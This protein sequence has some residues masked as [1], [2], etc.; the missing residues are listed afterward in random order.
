M[1]R[2]LETS[3]GQFHFI[4]D[5]AAARYAILSHTWG[6]PREGG[7]QSYADIREIQA[8]VAQE[9]QE[10]SSA[11]ASEA[12][13]EHSAAGPSILSHP[14]LSK[15][16]KEFCRVAREAGYHIV[17]IDSCCIDKSSSAE[18]SEAINSMFEWYS[19]ADVCCVYL[20]D[21]PEGDDLAEKRG[22]FRYSR[23]HR[24]G[25]TLQELIA[26]K[27]MVFFSRSWGFL[28]TKAGLAS[29]LEKI[30]GVDAAVL[31]GMTPLHSISVARRMSWASGRMTTLVE[32]EAY[33]LMGIFGV[34]LSPI[35]GERS[36][37]FVRLQEE[38]IRTI[39]DQSIFAWGPTC[40]LP[41]LQTVDNPFGDLERRRAGEFRPHEA[42][43]LAKSPGDFR[44]CRDVVSVSRKALSTLLGREDDSPH[45][46]PPL[47]C[48]FTPEGVRI[49]LPCIEFPSFPRSGD[50]GEGPLASG[51]GGNGSVRY[52]AVLRCRKG[53]GCFCALPLYR[54]SEREQEGLNVGAQPVKLSLPSTWNEEPWRVLL[55]NGSLPDGARSPLLVMDREV[56]IRRNTT[57]LIGDGSER[58]TSRGQLTLVGY[59]W[60]VVLAPWCADALRA[61]EFNIS[62][63]DRESEKSNAFTKYFRTVI[64]HRIPAEDPKHNHVEE[65]HIQVTLRPSGGEICVRHLVKQPSV[66]SDLP[67]ADVAMIPSDNSND[68]ILQELN[69]VSLDGGAAAR[70]FSWLAPTAVGDRYF[71]ESGGLFK[72]HA[73][74]AGLR[75]GAAAR[76]VRLLR[77]TL[78]ECEPSEQQRGPV[79][80]R[81]SGRLKPMW[82]QLSVDLSSAYEDT[83]SES[84]ELLSP[85]KSPF[86]GWTLAGNLG[87]RA[88]QHPSAASP[89][90]AEDLFQGKPAAVP[91]ASASESPPDAIAASITLAHGAPPPGVNGGDYV[92]SHAIYST[93]SCPSSSPSSSAPLGGETDS[94]LG[95]EPCHAGR[96]PL[97][98]PSAAPAALSESSRDH[99][100]GDD[101]ANVIDDPRPWGATTVTSKNNTL[102]RGSSWSLVAALSLVS[103]VSYFVL[104]Y[105]R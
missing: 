43:L 27:R 63:I 75:A 83:A 71:L 36:H 105:M 52:L 98:A 65:V 28:G 57:T 104:R 53:D 70:A 37:A 11:S 51:E 9:L 2:F 30:T 22:R 85:A 46:L 58:E 68:R 59:S 42:G 38:I 48:V 4:H 56:H 8:L 16:V 61:L 62:A 88:V 29:V 35:Y 41:R 82:F 34:Q 5:A 47:L 54:P 45:G 97:G 90:E 103:L 66:A 50:R 10:T 12:S 1:P 78:R 96:S 100:L 101:A 81:R 21:V 32:D 26:P 77:V 80:P 13:E 14:R 94:R 72:L 74:A 17:W 73:G 15:K 3:T 102:S 91:T 6:S 60:Q 20:A 95:R 69:V 39:P 25:W 76:N 79:A 24:R 84:A 40:I 92:S 86:V 87:G 33:A 55:L 18:L 93:V 99:E 49:T 31:T 67:P 7:E 89:S 23:W 64:S 44:H 19:R